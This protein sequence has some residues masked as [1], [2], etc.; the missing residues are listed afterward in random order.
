MFKALRTFKI[1]WIW[2]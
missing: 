1:I 2:L